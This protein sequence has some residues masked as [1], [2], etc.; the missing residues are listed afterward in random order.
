MNGVIVG[1]FLLGVVGLIFGA[2]FLVQG[3]ARLAVTVGVSPLVIGLTVV[4]F[5]TGAPELAVTL[6]AAWS[7]DPSMADLGVGNVVGSN[8]ANVLVVLGLSALVT[9]L[10]VRSRL[11]GWD[12][13]VMIVASVALLVLGH[14]GRL[15]RVDGAILFAG[16]L[17]YTIASIYHGR[18]VTARERAALAELDE[19]PERP[20][21]G[22]GQIALQFFFI[23]FGL[24]ILVVGADLLVQAATAIAKSLG[25]SELVIGLTVVAIGTSLPEMATS[26]IAG[27]KG[28]R[29][30]ALGNAVGSNIFNIFAVLGAAGLAAPEGVPVSRAALNFDIPVMIAVALTCLPVVYTGARIARR[31]GLLFLG[32]Y[33]AYLAYLYLKQGE[34]SLLEEFSTV[35]LLFVLPLTVLALGV[36]VVSAVRSGRTTHAIRSSNLGDRSG[37]SQD[38]RGTDGG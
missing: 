26:I 38:N 17:L 32:Y 6:R 14:D 27:L 37:S 31:E 35:M 33:V 7:G 9:P 20:A 29:E 25:V 2:R 16:I 19:V 4:A 12:V 15:S 28:E 8:I 34:H 23:V 24:S 10:V 3:A 1:Q 36:S 18:R 5:G 13:P 21:T 30:M 22:P 11:V